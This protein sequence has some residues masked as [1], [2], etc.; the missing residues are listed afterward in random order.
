MVTALASNLSVVIALVAILPAVTALAFSL[1]VLMA[2]SLIFVSVI[3]LFAIWPEVICP[4]MSAAGTE[5][6]KDQ[7]F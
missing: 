7:L 6:V 4:A 1:G 5:A 2:S 3:A